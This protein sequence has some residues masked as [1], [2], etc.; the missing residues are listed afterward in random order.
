MPERFKGRKL[1]RHNPTVTLMRTTVEENRAI[2][3][4]IAR[5]LNAMTRAGALPDSGRRRVGIDRPGQPFHD[6]EADRV[7]FDTIERDFRGGA[8]RKLR[9]LPLHINDEA[10]ADALVAAWREVAARRPRCARRA[11]PIANRE[12]HAPHRPPDHPR[13]LA[14]QDRRA[15]RRS[16][17]AAPARA[18]R[19]SAKRPAAST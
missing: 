4:F 19:P 11:E 9:R 8:N 17:A 7:L 12:A 2:G 10:F 16:S 5:K 3:E 13:Q 15:A 18:C 14:P 6:P 1:Y